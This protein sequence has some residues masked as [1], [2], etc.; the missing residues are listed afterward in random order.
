MHCWLLSRQL[1]LQHPQLHSVP[2][3]RR[4]QTESPRLG[5]KQTFTR[6]ETIDVGATPS[7]SLTTEA[8]ACASLK[9]RR[10]VTASTA[11]PGS[12]GLP[13]PRFPTEFV[14]HRLRKT[15]PSWKIVSSLS[16]TGVG[17]AADL[18]PSAMTKTGSFVVLPCDS[19][20]KPFSK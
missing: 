18:V 14:C 13:I 16:R 20:S 8:K 3:R 17:A 6:F 4:M 9:R 2:R 1:C 5:K 11:R 7:S 12:R 15:P 19:G 10:P